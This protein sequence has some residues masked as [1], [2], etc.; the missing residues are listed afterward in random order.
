MPSIRMIMQN[1]ESASP[2]GGGARGLRLLR[3]GPAPAAAIRARW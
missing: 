3:G 1:D 2:S